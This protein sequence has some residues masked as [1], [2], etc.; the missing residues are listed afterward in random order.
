MIGNVPSPVAA[1]ANDIPP[2]PQESSSVAMASSNMPPPIPPY[3]SGIKIP[4]ISDSPRIL[5]I[6]HGNSSFSSY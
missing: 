2:H 5:T 4:N 6:G 3:C 1:N